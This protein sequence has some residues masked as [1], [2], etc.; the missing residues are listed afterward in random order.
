MK[1]ERLN[2]KYIL[3]S[4]WLKVR[5]DTVRLPNGIIMDDYYV[6]EKNDV[7]LILAIDS[8]GNAIL[9]LEYRYPIDEM[10]LE[11]PGGTFDPEQETPLEAAK[12]ELL[13]ETGFVSSEW[14]ELGQFFDYPTKDTNRIY[15]FVAKNAQ[16]CADQKLD[17]SEQIELS[18]VLI[19]E[20]TQLISQNKIKVCGSITTIL[21]G[22][23]KLDYPS[24]N[25][26]DI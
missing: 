17:A 14:V 1:W 16:K 23:R 5:K 12:R 18:F 20:L 21:I 7:V 22:L 9:K 13:E 24:I 19:K 6:I 2:S 26:D 4:K 11:L 15:G 8:K 25:I 3:A 10:L